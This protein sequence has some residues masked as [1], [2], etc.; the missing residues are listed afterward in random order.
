MTQ[1]TIAAQTAPSD[2]AT[3]MSTRGAPLI[4]L[5]AMTPV[6]RVTAFHR[7]ELSLTHMRASAQHAP[8]E[9]PATSINGPGD[10][11][12]IPRCRADDLGDDLEG[13]RR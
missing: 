5:S 1:H 10:L 6:Q 8:H 9:D 12:W 2:A 13:A 4:A 7:D 11:P 3:R